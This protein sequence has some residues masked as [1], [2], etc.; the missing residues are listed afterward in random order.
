MGVRRLDTVRWIV[1]ALAFGALAGCGNSRTAVPTLQQPAAP[2]GYYAVAFPNSR[3]TLMAPRSWYL[4]EETGE[5]LAVINSHRAVIALWRYHRSATPPA[6][7]AQLAAK[8][9]SLLD[10]V[11]AKRGLL[12][13]LGSSTT[14][15]DNF[16]ALVLDALERVNRARREVRSTHVYVPGGELV[17]DEYAPPS[18]FGALQRTVFA[19]VAGSLRVRSRRG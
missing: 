12:R 5:L 6:D 4:T 16:P 19:R 17:L 18:Q 7:A 13:V 14:T 1:A 2:G 3:V 8:R 11:R 15:V 10:A 9:A